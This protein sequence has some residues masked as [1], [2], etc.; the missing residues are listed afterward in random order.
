VGRSDADLVLAAQQGDLDAFSRLVERYWSRLVGL[1]RSVVGD[2][3]AED[4]VQDG[5]V[6]AWDKLARLR[7]PGSFRAWI[8]RIITR[9]CIRRIQRRGNQV[10]LTAISEPTAPEGAGDVE[11]FH[12]EQVLSI[13]A[14]RQRAVMYFTVIEGMSDSEIGRA[15]GITAASVRSH[16]RRARER[17]QQVLHNES[18][19]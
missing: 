4:A 5:F 16:R 12:V 3:D 11:S 10:G 19:G 7:E 9:F 14:P 2:A 18:R 13:L 15:L 1:A 17:L 6:V 8:T